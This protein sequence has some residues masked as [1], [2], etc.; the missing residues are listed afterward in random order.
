MS[1]ISST[2][3]ATIVEA[4]LFIGKLQCGWSKLLPIDIIST[5]CLNQQI[6][7]VTKYCQ[8]HTPLVPFSCFF[9]DMRLGEESTSPKAQKAIIKDY[10][11]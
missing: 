6:K 7:F 2:V 10:T 3:D 4:E 1:K 11:G 5:A 9:L 8:I